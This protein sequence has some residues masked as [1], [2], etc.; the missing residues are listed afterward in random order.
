MQ[1]QDKKIIINLINIQLV[2]SSNLM[3]YNEQKTNLEKKFCNL[4]MMKK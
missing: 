3:S 4:I 1:S 2:V